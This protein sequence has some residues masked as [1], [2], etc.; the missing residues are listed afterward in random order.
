MRYD[1]DKRLTSRQC[2]EHVYLQETIPRDYITVPTGPQSTSSSSIPTVSSYVNGSHS[3]PSLPTPDHILPFHSQQFPDASISHRIPFPI[4]AQPQFPPQPVVAH[5]EYQHHPHGP[6]PDVQPDY[7]MA[8][9]Q[10]AHQPGRH[11]T[12]DHADDTQ[13]SPMV[14]DRPRHPE[15]P[16]DTSHV[17]VSQGN[18]LGKL[19]ATLKK[20]SRWALFGGDK[21]HHN[22][23][24]PVD[25]TS[26][27][28]AFPQRKRTKS[29]STDS[30]SLR[31]TSPV[32]EPTLN[33]RDEKKILEKN[34][35][36]AQ[37]LLR[38]A[39][40]AKRKLAYK[41]N[42]EQARAVMLKRKEVLQASAGEVPEWPRGPDRSGP[43]R[44]GQA[45]GSVAS[46]T[47]GAA[48]GKF[49]AHEPMRADQDGDR[50]WGGP[51]DRA[52]AR[53]REF[54]D[55]HSMSSSDLHSLSRVSSIS[56]ATVDSDPGPS[57]LRGQRSL[58]NISRMTS[59]SSLRTSFD[60]FPPS[61]RSSNSFS[62]EGQLVHD[63]R[64]QA[65]VSS[66]LSGS[67]SPPPLQLLTLSPTMSPSL[68]PSPPWIQVPQ[69]GKEDLLS[70][71]QSPPYLSISPRFHPSANPPHSPMEMNGQLP[72]LPPSS[73]GHPSSP[74]AY[75]P[76]TGHTPKSAKSAINPI[77]K[78][79][80]YK[81]DSADNLVPD[82]YSTQPPLPPPPLP[83]TIGD[84]QLTSA[85][86]LPP[87]SELE[88]VAGG[89]LPPLSPM[90]FSTPEDD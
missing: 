45:S 8:S 80:S 42:Q 78:V 79:V 47:I 9:P 32:R 86:V 59:R 29:S 44:R 27:A 1:P 71:I 64:T 36:E 66:H 56:F 12:D 39:E 14:Q 31:E 76:S 20:Q 90:V 18:K 24:P 52:K 50:E 53:R 65:S 28:L 33:P 49:A 83:T 5:N 89:D 25:E 34:K 17:H 7:P 37:R 13:D 55:D 15:P 70:Q 2:L 72:P 84:G 57:R 41:S 46:T 61:A 11:Y 23:L 26:P 4:P 74:Y 73:Y 6:W 10:D 30:R 85:N 58:Y 62:L 43:M 51:P 22:A 77:F 63:F 69:H 75:P 16:R 87:F 35:K 81:W 38:E 68:S 54:D 60:D 3:N 48:S 40:L 88:A 19:G 21:T 67:L 82:D